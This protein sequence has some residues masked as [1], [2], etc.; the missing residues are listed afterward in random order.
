MNIQ[1]TRFGEMQVNEKDIL[2]FPQGILG[3]P[4]SKNY[5]LIESEDP[6]IFAWLQSVNEPELCFIVT[7]PF[8]FKG[9]YS[10]NLT[11][12]EI[13]QLS[14]KT[15]KEVNILAIVSANARNNGRLTTN[16]MAPLVVNATNRV[17]YQIIKEEYTQ[18]LRF[19]I[20]QILQEMTAFNNNDLMAFQA[21]NY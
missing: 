14:V 21:V 15:A 3:F 7:D 20:K 5:I 9:D 1:T 11:T 19:D 2:S 10:V 18:L 13:E 6:S 4:E 8:L 17:G 12:Q 16:L